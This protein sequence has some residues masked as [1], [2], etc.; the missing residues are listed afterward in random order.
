MTMQTTQSHSVEIW[1]ASWYED[2][3]SIDFTS[4]RRNESTVDSCL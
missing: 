1:I 2:R 3:L 4:A